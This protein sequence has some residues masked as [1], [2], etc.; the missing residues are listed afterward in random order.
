MTLSRVDQLLECLF[1]REITTLIRLQ[2]HLSVVGMQGIGST[3]KYGYERFCMF[4][5][6][7]PGGDVRAFIDTLD[8][9]LGEAAAGSIMLPVLRALAAAHSL[10]VIHRDVKASNILLGMQGEVKLADWGISGEANSLPFD[11]LQPATPALQ[12]VDHDPMRQ[13]HESHPDTYGVAKYLVG[14][15]LDDIP[16]APASEFG[17]GTADLGSHFQS[18]RVNAYT[19][20]SCTLGQ[21]HTGLSTGAPVCREDLQAWQGT[22]IA[23]ECCNSQSDGKFR[24]EDEHTGCCFPGLLRGFSSAEGKRKETKARGS[25]S[26]PS[27]S[28]SP[29]GAQ[30]SIARDPATSTAVPSPQSPASTVVPSPQSPAS[31]AAPTTAIIPTSTGLG[32]SAPAESGMDLEDIR[33]TPTDPDNPT[34]AESRM[35]ME[36]I[37][38]TPTDPG[39]SAQPESRM[40]MEAIIPTTTDPGSSAQPE[41][42]MRMRDMRVTPSPPSSPSSPSSCSEDFATPKQPVDEI[43]G[44]AM[45]TPGWAAPELELGQPHDK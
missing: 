45:G 17:R 18:H 4:L 29:A 39:S 10:G 9:P 2:G 40:G 35:G 36:A 34:Q 5:D 28:S 16:E 32:S 31:T 12:C 43:R 15:A 38:P 19:A 24:E 11:P 14:G 42:G 25:G 21:S 13:Q 26:Y 6:W 7:M 1:T 8:A 22:G 3:N 30:S 33:A 20:L 23:S 27:L 37:I 44:Q 41:S